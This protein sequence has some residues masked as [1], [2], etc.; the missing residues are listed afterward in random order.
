M[1]NVYPEGSPVSL[2]FE[3]HNQADQPVYVLSWYTPLE[4][5]AGDIF[6]VTRDGEEL[7]YQGMMVKRGDPDE[8]SYISIEPGKS[9]SAEVELTTGYDLSVPGSY[10]VQFTNGLQDVT[11]DASL[12]PRKQNDHQ[13]QPLSCNS[14]SF[15]LVPAPE[16]ATPTPVV[17]VPPEGF[18]QYIDTDSGVSL[19]VP[20]DWTIVQ[21]GLQT[22]LPDGT[23][24]LQSYPEDKYVGGEPREE[25]DSKC[26]LT[27]HP[28]DVSVSDLIAKYKSDP[29]STILSEDKIILQS[30]RP[31]T[32]MEIESM[33]TALSLITE[34]NELTV[35]LTCFG[36]AE[37]FDKIAVTIGISE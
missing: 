25:G 8:E 32:R 19:W 2:R 26:D 18:K 1:D 21:A 6:L 27:I 3:L 33:G 7:S 9:A 17:I 31:G 22:G 20:E 13:A 29:L 36:D 12:L 35:T 24:R 10:Q 14:V 5:I 30:G 28:V 4:G 34:V 11:D 15:E 23:T 37:L 16:P